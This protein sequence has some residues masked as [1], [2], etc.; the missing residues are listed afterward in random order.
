MGGGDCF[1]VL[2]EVLVP[3]V[4]GFLLA[5]L[6]GGADDFEAGTLLADECR[7]VPFA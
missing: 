5:C 4:T 3:L 1:L 6:E 2:G 7:R